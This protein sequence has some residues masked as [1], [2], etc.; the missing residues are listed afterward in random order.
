[1]LY[2][3]EIKNIKTNEVIVVET[4]T[5]KKEYSTGRLGN[6]TEKHLL[7]IGLPNGKRFKWFDKYHYSVVIKEATTG[8]RIETLTY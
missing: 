2:E 8:R 6:K 7:Q 3:V 1:M 5:F 4:D